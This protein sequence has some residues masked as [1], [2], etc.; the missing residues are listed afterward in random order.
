[1]KD[2]ELRWSGNGDPVA[3]FC[4]A[5]PRMVQ[6]EFHA[7]RWVDYIECKIIRAGAQEF[8]KEFKKGAHMRLSGYLRQE[9]H[10]LPRGERSRLYVEAVIVERCEVMAC[11]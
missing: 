3:S 1:M 11:H 4:V 5:V 9:R 7:S 6:S 8:S 10:K 2:P